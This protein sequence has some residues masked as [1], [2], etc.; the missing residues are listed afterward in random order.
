MKQNMWLIQVVEYFIEKQDLISRNY[1]YSV[2]TVNLKQ[3][4]LQQNRFIWEKQRIAIGLMHSDG[5]PDMNLEE[6]REETFRGKREVGRVITTE[7]FKLCSDPRR[8]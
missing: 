2:T 7:F 5:K 6:K 3:I 1:L 8:A 4:F